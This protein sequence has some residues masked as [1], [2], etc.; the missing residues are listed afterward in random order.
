[1]STIFGSP[2]ERDYWG[3]RGNGGRLP[4]IRCPTCQQVGRYARQLSAI[5]QFMPERHFL[6]TEMHCQTCRQRITQ[7]ADSTQMTS[8]F[9]AR[10]RLILC[11]KCA[12]ELKR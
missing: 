3:E 2:V 11:L 9:C 6:T 12:L 7:R 5:Y 4:S 1:M 8:W 10:C